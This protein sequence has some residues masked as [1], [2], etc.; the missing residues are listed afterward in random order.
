MYIAQ[1]YT[2]WIKT[3]IHVIEIPFTKSHQK[4]MMTDGP[5]FKLLTLKSWGAIPVNTHPVPIFTFP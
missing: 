3:A 4:Y 2:K 5:N 1:R